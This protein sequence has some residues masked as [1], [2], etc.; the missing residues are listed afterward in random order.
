MEIENHLQVAKQIFKNHNLDGVRVCFEIASWNSSDGN[1][2]TYFH[3]H[4]QHDDLPH[5]NSG[6]GDSNFLNLL[7]KIETTIVK[8]LFEKLKVNQ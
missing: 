5:F 1:M 6:V 2:K 4:V 7:A 3:V 8:E